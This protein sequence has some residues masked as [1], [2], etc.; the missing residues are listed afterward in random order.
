[1]FHQLIERHGAPAILGQPL[2]RVAQF[3]DRAS[4]RYSL[5]P[6]LEPHPSLAELHAA[7]S[8]LEESPGIS[9]VWLA[10]AEMDRNEPIADAVV[11]KGLREAPALVA[12]A[13][14]YGA[15]GVV[16]ACDAVRAQVGEVVAG[17]GVWQVVW[18]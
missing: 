15:D 1:M 8:S 16:A 7:L 14:S 2:W 4:D 9:G 18:D 13:T 10:I 3:F 5:L 6:N 12:F 17:E 11:V